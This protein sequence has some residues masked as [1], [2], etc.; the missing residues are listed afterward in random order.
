MFAVAPRH[1]FC[2]QGRPYLPCSAAITMQQP[3]LSMHTNMHYTPGTIHSMHTNM[4]YTPGTTHSMHCLPQLFYAYKNTRQ[5]WQNGTRYRDGESTLHVLVFI[6]KTICDFLLYNQ[7]VTAI[8]MLS[9]GLASI[10]LIT[11]SGD[12]TNLL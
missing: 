12:E 4:R 7:A 3:T 1:G 8:C 2:I 5:S 6:Q 10:S 9:R 11:R